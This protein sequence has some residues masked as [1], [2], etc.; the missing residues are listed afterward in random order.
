MH[1]D[2]TKLRQNLF[3]LL[4]NAAKFTEARHD[5]AEGAARQRGRTAT[6]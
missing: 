5:H 2:Q 3:N 6:G 4:S 1:S